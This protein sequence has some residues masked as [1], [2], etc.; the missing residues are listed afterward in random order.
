MKF[1]IIDKIKKFIKLTI[2]DPFFFRV[3]FLLSANTENRAILIGSPV[4]NN[5]GD[6]LIAIQTVEYIK[7]LGYSNIIEIP[8]FVYELYSKFLRLQKSDIVFISGG[9]WMGN[10]YEDESVIEDILYR[11]A[12]NCIIILPQTIYFEESKNIMCD[13]SSLKKAIA[14]ANNLIICVRDLYSYEFAQKELMELSKCLLVPDMGMLALNSIR[15]VDN[16]QKFRIGVSLRDDI[17]RSGVII[18][19]RFYTYF[20]DMGYR[21]EYIS[22][23]GKGK[24]VRFK[25]RKKILEKKID[26]FN[27]YDLIITDRLHSAILALLAGVKCIAIDNKTHKIDGV[28]KAWLNNCTG[29]SIIDKD[30]FNGSEIYNEYMKIKKPQ[31]VNFWSDM[32]KLTR[33]INYA[34]YD[35]NT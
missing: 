29:L 10:L 14:R 17:E 27:K 30:K 13:I 35:K 32:D 16:T 2:S 5:L 4:H 26:E 6:H 9:G 1:T 24:I 25:N 19:D 18:Q 33:M 23:F 28:Y 21:I 7:S 20:E 12:E 8:E 3:F 11:Y 34:R 31:N 15:K 22:S